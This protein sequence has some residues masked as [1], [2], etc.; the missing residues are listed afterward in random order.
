MGVRDRFEV[1]SDPE[2][3]LTWAIAVGSVITLVV[4][5]R[6]FRDVNPG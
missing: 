1:P 4:L 5:A 2:L 6:V 3:R